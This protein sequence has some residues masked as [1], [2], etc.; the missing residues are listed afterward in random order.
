MTERTITDTCPRCGSE[1]T[2]C[3][4]KVTF[5][6]FGV[7]AG[8]GENRFLLWDFWCYDCDTRWIAREGGENPH[9][10]NRGEE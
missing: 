3:T 2:D 1:N 8:T 9:I 4:Q 5:D 10:V 6:G 7:Y